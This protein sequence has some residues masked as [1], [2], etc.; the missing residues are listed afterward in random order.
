MCKSYLVMKVTEVKEVMAC[1][2]ICV[3][4]Y[5]LRLLLRP[6]SAL[7][8]YKP[9]NEPAG[10]FYCATLICFQQPNIGLLG[11]KMGLKG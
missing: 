7:L 9:T 10:W 4:L 2:H 5:T 6:L 11:P 3:S 1:V 8:V